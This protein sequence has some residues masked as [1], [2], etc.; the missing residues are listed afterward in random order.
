MTRCAH[1]TVA[2]LASRS[3][4]GMANR[5]A[6]PIR[7]GLVGL[8]EVLINE[9]ARF[10]DLVLHAENKSWTITACLEFYCGPILY[11]SSISIKDPNI[12][13]SR[14]RKNMCACSE[15]RR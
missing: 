10:D 6:Q 1:F 12:V 3:H 7:F 4:R 11:Y 2:T 5:H 14:L 13:V 15:A 9:T 8:H